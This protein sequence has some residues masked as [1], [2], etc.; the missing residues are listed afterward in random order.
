ML[1]SVGKGMMHFTGCLGFIVSCLTGVGLL[2]ILDGVPPSLPTVDLPM[3]L[4]MP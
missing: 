4:L 3:H 2:L 1:E